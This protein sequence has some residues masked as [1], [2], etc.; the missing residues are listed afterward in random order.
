M[1]WV[2]IANGENAGSVRNKINVFCSNAARDI[3][4]FDDENNLLKYDRNVTTQDDD[5][6]PTVIQYTRPSDDSL[7]LKRTYSNADSNGYYQ[8]CT[9]LFYG[10]DGTTVYK[11]IVYTFTFF[12][13][14]LIETATRVVS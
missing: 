13:N 5:D 9:E 4:E 3:K 7:F 8:T 14:G 11:T 10:S 2:D 12:D 6:N 1:A